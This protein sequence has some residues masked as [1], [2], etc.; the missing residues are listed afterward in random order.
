[1]KFN[2]TKY[3]VLDF[4]HNNRRQ[5]Y[6]LEADW[7]EDSVEE[8]DLVMLFNNRLNVSQLYT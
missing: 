1:M 2:K 4:G 3:Q 8:K 6:R 7:L 5:Y